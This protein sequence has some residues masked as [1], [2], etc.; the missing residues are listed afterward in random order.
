ME[1]WDKLRKMEQILKE[2]CLENM[3]EIYGLKEINK[4]MV[5]VTSNQ[6]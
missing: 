3:K 6:S 4:E 1:V 2:F 5:R